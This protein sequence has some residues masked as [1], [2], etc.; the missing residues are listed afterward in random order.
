MYINVCSGHTGCGKVRHGMVHSQ[1]NF[2]FDGHVRYRKG[3]DNMVTA[4]KM[5]L[6]ETDIPLTC[7]PP[8]ISTQVQL[9]AV[10][11]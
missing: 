10:Y 4:L 5:E 9:D 6:E 11:R 7:A 1:Q 2:Y 8:G 3:K